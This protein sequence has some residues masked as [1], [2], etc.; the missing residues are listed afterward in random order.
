MTD[1]IRQLIIHE[2]DA[3]KALLLLKNEK[4]G[5]SALEPTRVFSK[6]DPVEQLRVRIDDKL[7]RIRTSGESA[8]DEDTTQDLMGYLVLLRVAAK[9]QKRGAK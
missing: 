5:N 4:Y 1:D 6:A 9:L 3:L 8:A 7:S 2:C